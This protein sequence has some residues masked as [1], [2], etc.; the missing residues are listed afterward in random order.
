MVFCY[1]ITFQ[2]KTNSNEINFVA[3]LQ[4]VMII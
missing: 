4:L 2:A 1:V 3:A